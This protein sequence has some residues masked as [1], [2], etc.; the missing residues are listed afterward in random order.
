MR[1]SFLP[2]LITF[3]RM[4]LA[5]PL[6]WAILEQRPGLA[7]ILATVAGGSDAL[8][9]F[10]AKRYHWQSWLGGIIDPLAD[11]LMLL[12]AY[13]SLALTDH[14]DW[15]LFG[16][17]VVRDLLI[18][19]GALVYHY[20]IARLEAAPSAWS[21]ATTFLQIVLVLVILGDLLAPAV[22][23]DTLRDGLAWLTALVTVI[24]GVDYVRVWSRRAAELRTTGSPR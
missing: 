8:D 2:N 24:S 18:V 21:K 11:K 20:R 5:P 12:A 15:W 9:G 3:A 1:W 6:A 22:S 23:L 10:L 16:L 7:L 19:S 14:V 13:L 17:I 4:L